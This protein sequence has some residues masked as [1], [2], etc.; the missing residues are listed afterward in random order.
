MPST[1]D[2]V[3]LAVDDATVTLGAQFREVALGLLITGLNPAS[4][5]YAWYFLVGS[6]PGLVLPRAYSWVSRRF[7]AKRVM[8]ATYAA[9][10]VLVLGLWRVVNFWA[11]L[12]LL[13]GLSV[14]GSMRPRRPIMWPSPT[15]LL[16]LAT[17]SC[18]YGSRRAPY[19]LWV[20]SSPGSFSLRSGSATDLSLRRVAM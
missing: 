11:A 12:A 7:S 20:P 3:L 16:P 13:G 6:I 8:L 2:V 10:L 18:A 9:R 17:S 4:S 14:A 19:G 15:T 5:S 1:K